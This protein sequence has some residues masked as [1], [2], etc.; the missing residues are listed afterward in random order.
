MSFSPAQ[1]RL[2]LKPS[3]LSKPPSLFLMVPSAPRGCAKT[4]FSVGIFFFVQCVAFA[5]LV[6]RLLSEGVALCVAEGSVC[7]WEEMS[8]GACCVAIVDRNLLFLISYV[9]FISKSGIA[10]S[11]GNSILTFL[12]N[13][14]TV[15][16]RGCTILLSY[17]Q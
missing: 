17:Q 8:S 13:W 4:H 15:F 6:S 11:S 14:Q 12:R 7:P 2:S 1:T 3:R 9:R 16:H 10:E 5:Q